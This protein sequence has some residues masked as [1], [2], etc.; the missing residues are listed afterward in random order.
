MSRVIGLA[1]GV[2]LGASGAMAQDGR[3]PDFAT[4]MD[5]EAD[6][7][8]WKLRIHRKRDIDAADFYLWNV[9]GVEYCGNIAITRCDRSDDPIPCQQALVGAQLDLHREVLVHLPAPDTL[10]DADGDLA[11]ELYVRAYD[12]AHGISAGPDCDGSDDPIYTWCEAREANNRLQNAVLAWQVARWL[13][14]AEPARVAGWAK[15]PPPVR[16]RVRPEE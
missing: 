10:S 11:N 4:C 14:A 1:M 12:L 9:L 8:E 5:I 3:L 16:P 2:V 15:A 6:R 7:F 13:G